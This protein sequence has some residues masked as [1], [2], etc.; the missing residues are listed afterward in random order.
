[1]VV[2]QRQLHER[3]QAIETAGVNQLVVRKGQTPELAVTRKAVNPAHLVLGQQHVGKLGALRQW[4]QTVDLVAREPERPE[5]LVSRQ[6]LDIGDL[7]A[8]GLQRG[9]LRTRLGPRER[10]DV[11]EVDPRHLKLVQGRQLVHLASREIDPRQVELLELGQGFEEVDVIDALNRRQHQRRQRR[12]APE[13]AG[14][15]FDGHRL[16][17]QQLKRVHRLWE[18]GIEIDALHGREVQA[19]QTAHAIQHFEGAEPGARVQGDA[20][21]GLRSRQYLERLVGHHAAREGHGLLLRVVG[22]SACRLW[23][24]RLLAD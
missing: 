16:Q 1:M 19:H 11:A 14:A 22:E 18:K 8:L 24:D 12:E 17:T 7:V 23:T 6:R 9:E 15:S 20:L 13:C 21:D 2:L 3:R 4:P 5:S 10:V